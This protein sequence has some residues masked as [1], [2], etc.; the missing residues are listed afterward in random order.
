VTKHARLL[1]FFLLLFS[2]AVATL[3]RAGTYTAASC[4][5]SDVNAVI[6]GPTN[7]A[8][9]GDTII[10]PAGTCTWT[11]SLSIT[12]G[13]TLQGA[14]TPNTLPSQFGSGTLTTIIKSNVSSSSPMITVTGLTFGQT[15]RISTL[16]IEPNSNVTSLRTPLEFAGTCTASGCP[17]MRV[18]NIG[19]GLTTPWT[20]TGN[21][22]PATSMIRTDNFFGV[23][24]HNTMP[25]GSNS[26]F[27]NINHSAYLGVG[28]FGDNSWAT[29]DSTGTGNAIFLENNLLANSIDITDTEFGPNGG[30]IGGGRF[31]GRFNHINSITNSF[32]SFLGHGLDTNGRPQ[33]MRQVEAYGNVITIAG[34]PGNTAC[35]SARAGGVGHCWGNTINSDYSG[36]GGFY[37]AVNNITTYRVVDQNSAFATCDGTS[38]WDTNDGTTLYSGTATS[39]GLT[40]NVSG[41]PGFTTNQLIPNGA[42]YSVHDATQNFG[43]EVVSNT[44][45]SITIQGPIHGSWTQV[46]NGDT[47][48]VQRATVCADQG[49]RGQGNLIS[50]STPASS[51][52]LS[53]ALDPMFTVMNSYTTGNNPNQG[54]TTTN[55]LRSIANRDWYDEPL[56]QAAQTSA[57]SPFN[58]SSGAGHG[59]LSR[60]PTTC[61]TGVVYLATDQGSWNTSGNG[62]GQGSFYKCTSTNTWNP[63]YTPYAYPHP[64]ES[65][66]STTGSGPGAAANLKATAF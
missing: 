46:N 35:I 47:I 60:R 19:F 4:N 36:T 29:A 26:T 59:I 30:A 42:P 63:L 3:A 27:A 56:N 31:V 64:L 8:V 61:T 40:F 32:G 1:S 17:L 37:N 50:G 45:G 25:S 54:I 48:T 44:S 38:P 24:D 41:S 66:G 16:D 58:G 13:L 9:D 23:L 49:G 20:E 62:F 55:T 34:G 2:P 18:D 65:N 33:G 28:A 15:V 43:S 6:S 14:G 22:A 53:Q 52:A 51:A 57:T 12:V 11:S 10:I 39:S 7:K 21:G 5:E